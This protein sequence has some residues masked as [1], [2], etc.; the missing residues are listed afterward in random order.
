MFEI[1]D[2]KIL[3]SNDYIELEKLVKEAIEAGYRPQ[4]GIAFHKTQ[5]YGEVFYYQAVVLEI[6][7]E[8]QKTVHRVTL[9]KD[10]VV[11]EPKKLIRPDIVEDVHLDYLD[12]LRESD[13]TN[14]LGAAPYLQNEFNLEHNDAI[15]VL[16]YWMESFQQEV[17]EETD[18][19]ESGK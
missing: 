18:K 12:Q 17:K 5:L 9:V 2:Y 13:E 16:K 4:G 8:D 11:E 15:V 14:M 7:V 3:K 6:D 1:Q 19:N 10:K